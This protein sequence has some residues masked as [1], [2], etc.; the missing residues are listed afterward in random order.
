MRH[1]AD[2]RTTATSWGNMASSVIISV[3]E[4]IPWRLIRG[5]GSGVVSG[6]P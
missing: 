3:R 2:A 6:L 1:R 5:T 4:E